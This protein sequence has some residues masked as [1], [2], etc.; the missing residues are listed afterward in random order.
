MRPIFFVFLV[1]IFFSAQSAFAEGLS[2]VVQKQPM[3]VEKGEF[4]PDTVVDPEVKMVYGG[5]SQLYGIFGYNI[6]IETYGVKVDDIEAKVVVLMNAK[7][8]CPKNTQLISIASLKNVATG[9]TVA[10]PLDRI[11]AISSSI[12]RCVSKTERVSLLGTSVLSSDKKSANQYHI[13]CSAN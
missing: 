11:S 1:S 13:F 9:M 4:V 12:F 8:L 5:V 6:D 3:K 7:S 2:C 10:A